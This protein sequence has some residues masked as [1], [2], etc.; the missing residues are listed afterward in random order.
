LTEAPYCSKFIDDVIKAKNIRDG[1]IIISSGSV[2]E[3]TYH[4]VASTALKAQN[5]YRTVRGPSE[6]VPL[7]NPICRRLGDVQPGN[8]KICKGD[9]IVELK[10]WSGRSRFDG[11][12]V[13]GGQDV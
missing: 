9:R 12:G 6:I 8:N 13:R 2:Q 5:E 1:Q 10:R 3:C 7:G 4:Y 11:I